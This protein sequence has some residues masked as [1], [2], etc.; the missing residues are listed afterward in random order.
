MILGAETVTRRRFAAPTRDSDGYTVAGASTDSDI[1]M[2]VQPLTDREL[3]TL[4]EG[5]RMGRVLKGYTQA[6]VRTL[7]DK[8]SPV[9]PADHIIMDSVVYEVRAVVEERK[10]IPHKRVRLMQLLE[11][12]G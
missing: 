11:A 6:D 12:D 9:A 3:A 2:S 1:R 7:D 5:E 8:A 10:I 4:P